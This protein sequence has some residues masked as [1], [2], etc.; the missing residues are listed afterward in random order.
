MV[1]KHQD[2]S[3]TGDKKLSEKRLTL[4]ASVSE[5]KKLTRWSL[6]LQYSQNN[7]YSWQCKPQ[8]LPVWDRGTHGSSAKENVRAVRRQKVPSHQPRPVRGQTCFDDVLEVLGPGEVE[9][10]GGNALGSQR[11]VLQRCRCAAHAFVRCR[12]ESRQK[13]VGRRL[14]NRG[15]PDWAASTKRATAWWSSARL[16]SVFAHE[17]RLLSETRREKSCVGRRQ[18]DEGTE[19]H[20]EAKTVVVSLWDLYSLAVTSHVNKLNNLCSP[21]VEETVCK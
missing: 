14:R 3:K 9:H 11:P 15:S 6:C 4:W 19:R 12:V 1:Q 5:L 16:D 18:E 21:T 13:H 7:H 10:P 8:D 2:Y 17:R 20:F